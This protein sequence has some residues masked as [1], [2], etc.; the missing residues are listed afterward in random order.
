MAP[1]RKDDEIRVSN[2]GYCKVYLKTAFS[3][4]SLICAVHE[5]IEK[6]DSLTWDLHSDA[7]RAS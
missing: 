4:E 1:A 6:K 7:L 3:T 2:D 5:N